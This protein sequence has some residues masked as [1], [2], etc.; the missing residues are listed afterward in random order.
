MSFCLPMV[1]TPFKE[2][3]CWK[4]D[5]TRAEVEAYTRWE[6]YAMVIASTEVD[7]GIS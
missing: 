5:K 7:D 6:S 1:E 2:C 3:S 4:P